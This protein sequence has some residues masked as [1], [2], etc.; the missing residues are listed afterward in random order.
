MR[1]SANP[2]AMPRSRPHD[3]HAA[4]RPRVPGRPPS[5]NGSLLLPIPQRRRD[6]R[7]G[8][9]GIKLVRKVKELWFNRIMLDS[10]RWLKLLLS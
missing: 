1:A 3:F 8:P 10:D 5:A 2:A 9:D 4:V 7:G 6:H